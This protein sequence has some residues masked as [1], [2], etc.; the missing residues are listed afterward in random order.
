MTAPEDLLAWSRNHYHNTADL[1]LYDRIVHAWYSV[2]P[3][4]RQAAHW[5]MDVAWLARIKDM[6]DSKGGKLWAGDASRL[7]GVPFEVRPD[8]GFPHLEARK[9]TNDG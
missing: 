7:L 6:R 3:R 4:H 2:L 5:V 1:E 9:A 8:G